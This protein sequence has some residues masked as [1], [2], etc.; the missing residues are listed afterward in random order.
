VSITGQLGV[1][2]RDAKG[3]LGTIRLQ[4][5]KLTGS[6]PIAQKIADSYL[7][8]AGGDAGKA[9]SALASMNN[10]Y[11]WATTTPSDPS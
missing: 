1:T 9:L 11:L 10:G 3:P 8:R 5:G 2:L 6:D 7:A 4:D